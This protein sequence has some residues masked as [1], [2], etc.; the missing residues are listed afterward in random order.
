MSPVVRGLKSS[1]IVF[2]KLRSP[3]RSRPSWLQSPRTTPVSWNNQ[4]NILVVLLISAQHLS[5]SLGRHSRHRPSIKPILFSGNS[6][7]RCKDLHSRRSG[8]RN[9]WLSTSRKCYKCK[10]VSTDLRPKTLKSALLTLCWAAQFQA[11]CRKLCCTLAP[12]AEKH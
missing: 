4:K 1:R 7:W 10:P 3:M 9:L 8:R 2:S 11:T 5:L 6:Q 12:I